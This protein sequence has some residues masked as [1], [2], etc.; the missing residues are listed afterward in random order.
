MRI[1]YAH[2]MVYL[3]TLTFLTTDTNFWGFSN[4]PI[5]RLGLVHFRASTLPQRS[6]SST[7]PALKKSKSK[8]KSEAPLPEKPNL[9]E[10]T[11]AVDDAYDFSG[12]Q[13]KILK[14][15]EYLTHQLAQLRA[16]GRFNPEVLEELKVPLKAAKEGGKVGTTKVKDLAQVVAKGRTVSVICHEEDVRSLLPS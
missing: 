13:A 16:G 3:P 10:Q 2:T 5:Q 7:A 6:F 15:T 4:I 14:A 12:L 11:T 8:A 1:A 9:A